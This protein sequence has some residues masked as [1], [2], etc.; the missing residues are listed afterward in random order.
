VILSVGRPADGA[1]RWL[2]LVGFSR[3]LRL[4]CP[5][6][7]VN[8]RQIGVAVPR[9]NE[10]IT[11]V[12]AAVAGSWRWIRTWVLSSGGLLL[13]GALLLVGW[14][15][16][17]WVPPA[18]RWLWHWWP[19]PLA[20]ALAVWGSLLLDR[21]RRKQSQ[22]TSPTPVPP[23]LS[24]RAIVLSSVLVL[25]LATVAMVVM[26]RVY[27]GGGPTTQLEAIRTAGT[28]V[29]GT[30]GA[31][32]LLLTAR[33]QRWTELTLKHQERVARDTLT[34]QEKVAAATEA[35]A[36]R[37]RITDLYGKA[38]DQLGSEK[39]PVR[40]AG[41]Y[42]LERLGQEAPPQRQMIVNVLCAYLR[43]PYTPPTDFPPADREPQKQHT[44]FEQRTQ[45]LQ[46]RRAAQRILH[47]HFGVGDPHSWNPVVVDLSGAYLRDADFDALELTGAK[48]QR[49]D[50]RGAD[51]RASDLRSAMFADANLQGADLA[52]ANLQDANLQE[53]DLQGANLEKTNVRG[54]DAEGA[55][56]DRP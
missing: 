14:L 39:A 47:D 2:G 25:V 52:Y 38:A 12:R 9:T 56:Y 6:P 19:A 18:V 48:F 42:A 41:L 24:V 17:A 33:R 5:L 31:I 26:L 10:A 27:G 54:A 1:P 21:R 4:Y 32:A 34:H 28:I 46:V 8:M 50:L 15:T 37:R 35:D 29:V 20:V 30:G 11:S 13:V 49:A 55:V 22:S 53:A 7:K 40:L 36:D 51:L 23:A 43:M 44:R 45:E 3:S 16:W